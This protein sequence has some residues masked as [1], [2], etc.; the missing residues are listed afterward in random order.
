MEETKYRLWDT[1]IKALGFVATALSIYFGL[2]N[3]NR[4]Q[5]ATADLEFRRNFWVKQTEVYSEVCKNAG[6]LIASIND[7]QAFNAEKEKFLGAYYGQMILVEDESVDSAMRELKSYV[8]IV[9]I[10]DEGMV[11]ILKRKTV[12]LAEACKQSAMFFKKSTQ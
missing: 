4:Q 11:N 7:R 3:F 12:R 9:D 10:K 2:I 8:E 5:A 1:I 6:T